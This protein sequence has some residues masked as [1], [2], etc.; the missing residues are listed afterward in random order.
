MA[1]RIDYAISITPIQTN[2]VFEGVVQ[3][4]IESDVGRSLA[5]SKSD[6]TWTGTTNWS[7]TD[8]LHKQSRTSSNT[9]A[10]VV[11]TDGLWIKHTGFKYVSGLST[12]AEATTK[13][14]VSRRVGF[15]EFQG[16]SPTVSSS[17]VT[18]DGGT[19]DVQIAKTKKADAGDLFD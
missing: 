9:I 5:G 19:I 2:T 8:A 11:G 6:S 10:T 7:S 15:A 17:A 1:G 13:V 18:L 16:G 12:T 14:I 3:E 4:A